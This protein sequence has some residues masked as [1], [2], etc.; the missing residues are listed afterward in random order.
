M[1][2][3]HRGF[4]KL[5]EFTRP[6]LTKQGALPGATHPYHRDSQAGCEKGECDEDS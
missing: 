5:L 3:A 2:T 6:S 4:E 1:T